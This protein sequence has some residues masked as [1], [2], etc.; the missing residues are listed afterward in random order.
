[1]ISA[2]WIYWL[3]GGFFFIVGMQIAF[4]REHP[5]RWTN[6]ALWCLFGASLCAGSFVRGPGGSPAA[7]HPT[8]PSWLL[9]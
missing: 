2:E 9:G 7:M 8:M 4:D 6:A 1:M 5:K 3:C